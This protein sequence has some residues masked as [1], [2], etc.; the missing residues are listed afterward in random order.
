[1]H[2]NAPRSP[3]IDF[4][5]Y[6]YNLSFFFLQTLKHGQKEVYL[7]CG[8]SWLDVWRE[9]EEEQRLPRLRIL[10]L[11]VWRGG[12]PRPHRGCRHLL[13]RADQPPGRPTYTSSRTDLGGLFRRTAISIWL[14]FW[15][16]PPAVDGCV[17]LDT[18]L[19]P[20]VS[21]VAAILSLCVAWPHH[22]TRR[23]SIQWVRAMCT[24]R[25]V[26]VG[27]KLGHVGPW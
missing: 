17:Q 10:Q 16:I 11:S 3:L 8:L 20:G 5:L 25:D 13:H 2:P 7:M 14:P 21:P 18:Q 12:R 24:V 26:T 6:L 22:Y 15:Q 27:L 4:T 19:P 1:M 9:H 23:A